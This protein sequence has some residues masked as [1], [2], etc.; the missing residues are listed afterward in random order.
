L[1]PREQRTAGPRP[2]GWLV[3][4]N[5]IHL[6]VIEAAADPA[7]EFWRNI[8]AIDDLAEAILTT[9]GQIT[10]AALQG[11]AAAGGLMLALAADE[12]WCRDGVVPNPHY[13]LMGLYGSE[14]WT[15]TLPRRVG[16]PEAAAHRHMPA[17]Q[18]RSGVAIRPGRPGDRRH[19]SHLSRAS[20]GPCRKAG[21]QP[22]LPTAAGRKSATADRR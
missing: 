19:T 18:S 9:T 1:S 17:G 6:N 2:R 22:R 15:Y 7:A 16:A 8:N 21:Q 3:F 4:S 13:R 14:Y 10:V 11:N 5:G 12:V 20:G